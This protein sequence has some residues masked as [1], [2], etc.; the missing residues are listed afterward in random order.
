M[1]ADPSPG[2]AAA[3]P[4]APPSAKAQGADHQRHRGIA[5]G[6]LSGGAGIMGGRISGLL[7]DMVFAHA[8]GTGSALGAFLLAF[9]LPNLAR[10]FLG[11]GALTDAFVPILNQ[12]L[13]QDGRDAAFVLVNRVL[14][15]VA[16]VAGIGVIAVAILALGIR[17]FVTN[18]LWRQALWLAPFLLPYA[19]L[20]CLAAQLGAVL[21][22]LGRFALPAWGSVWLNL[23]FIVASLWVAPRLDQP[24][25]ALVGGVLVSGILQAGLLLPPLW[26]LG[27]RPAVHLDFRAPGLRAV[28]ALMLPGLLGAA[29]YQ[30]NVLAD[31]VFAAW[32]GD[33][34][35]TSLYYAERLVFLPVGIFAV[36]LTAAALPAMSRAWSRQDDHA[37]ESAFAYSM[38]HVLY[39]STP[40]LLGLVLLAE[41][42]CRL[43]F[44]RHGG[45]F[46]A[47][48]L[49]YTR[50][51]LLYYSLGIPAFAA[52]KIVRAGFYSRQDAR[53]PVR[54][55]IFCILLNLVLNFAFIVPLQQRGL[56]LAT[57][58][59]STLNVVILIVILLRRVRFSPAVRAELGLFALR[60]TVCLSAAGLA[61]HFLARAIPAGDSFSSQLLAVC[62]PLAAGAVAY[63]LAAIPLRATELR[64]LLAV[65]RRRK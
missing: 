18:A 32:L 62:V 16:V 9:T 35:V 58:I 22:S 57:A 31:R 52:L 26:K 47:D 46:D 5:A 54:V 38:R 53:T 10:R 48:S 45:Q 37:A 42:I 27:W 56:A 64:E 1:A 8:W 28:L 41:P 3:A 55:S 6:F 33:W 23:G 19:L 50:D 24:A 59:S 25:Y 11:E 49:R 63:N 4:A 65:I 43:I 40:C 20:I 7:R 21:N 39:L 17:P 15:W 13:E 12:R 36:A 51:A 30:V 34:A 60:L 14:C 2:E 61:I 29:V 44:M